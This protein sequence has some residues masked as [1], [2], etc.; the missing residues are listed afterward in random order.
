MKAGDV[1]FRK[2]D[3][4]DRLFLVVDGQVR[5]TEIG[6]VMEPGKVFG[7]IAFFSPD[8]R[9]TLTAL[10]AEDGTLLT[11][12]EPTVKQL[13]YQNPQFGFLMI[14]LVAGRL[15]ADVKRLENRLAELQS[16]SGLAP[17]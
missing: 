12:D 15:S 9:R 11:I 8:R 14:S 17:G 4:A 13:Y 5:F 1:L 16:T 2:G 7:E 10:C 3:Q 6:V